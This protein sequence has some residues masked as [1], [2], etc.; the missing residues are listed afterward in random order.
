MKN[1]SS[2]DHQDI[3]RQYNDMIDAIH[4]GIADEQIAILTATT[5]FRAY[6]AYH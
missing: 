5:V 1:I 2:A 4:I 3:K 6:D